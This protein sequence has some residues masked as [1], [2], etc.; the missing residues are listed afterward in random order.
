[1]K[2]V[3]SSSRRRDASNYAISFG[4]DKSLAR[5]RLRLGREAVEPE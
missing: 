2:S 4:S 1:M 5:Y 3:A